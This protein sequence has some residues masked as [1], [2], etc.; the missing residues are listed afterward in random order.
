MG[1][2][3]PGTLNRSLEEFRALGYLIVPKLLSREE[4]AS[5]HHAFELIPRGH[6]VAHGRNFYNERMLLQDERFLGVLTR[7]R[8]VELLRKIVGD[9]LQLLSYDA[10]ETPAGAGSE[11]GWHIELHGFSSDTLLAVNVGVYL[12]DVTDEIG[13]LYI[14]PGSHHWRREPSPEESSVP[15]PEEVKVRVP[16]GTCI[17]IDGC[18]WHSASHNRSTEVRRALFAYVGH[19]WMKRMDEFY[20]RPLPSYILESDDPLVR[21]LFGLELTLAP[22]LYGDGYRRGGG[23]H[24]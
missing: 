20:E 9:D 13:P 10:P 18:L 1:T 22:S 17:I 5:L 11:R 19:F 23:T 4:A 2:L 21:Q 6:D 24:T 8:L 15:H 12:Q 16:A 3:A 7:P 14:I